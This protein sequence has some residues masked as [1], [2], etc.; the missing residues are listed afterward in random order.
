[1][2]L[3]DLSPYH[4]VITAQPQRFTDWFG[5]TPNEIV[6]RSMTTLAMEQVGF[7][8]EFEPAGRGL[9]PW[10]MAA[11]DNRSRLLRLARGARLCWACPGDSPP[12]PPPPLGRTAVPQDVMAS[13]VDMSTSA[14]ERDFQ[15]G[16]IK[17]N[18]VNL[19]H[20]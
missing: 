6:G 3:A 10:R 9:A 13:L 7:E 1:M 15:R 5:K 11:A 12:V 2:L 16:K 4:P 8:F 14:T 17:A 18:G 19:L 20:K